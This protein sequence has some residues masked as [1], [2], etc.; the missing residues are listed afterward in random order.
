MLSKIISASTIGIESFLVEVEIDISG[1]IPCFQVVGLPDAT[2]RESRNRIISAIKNTGI[3]FPNKKITVNLA[4]ADIKK[5][6]VNFDLPIAIGILTAANYIKKEKIKDFI[7]C[8][9]LSLNGE[10]KPIKGALPIALNKYS[11]KSL[12]LPSDN[13]KE[14]EIVKSRK[15][16]SINHLREAIDFFNETG[17]LKIINKE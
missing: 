13:A 2:I 8:G 16:Y 5:E 7:I 12:I 11:K 10:I 14:V 4:P 6:G 3:K 1:G 9:Q 17:S 15:L